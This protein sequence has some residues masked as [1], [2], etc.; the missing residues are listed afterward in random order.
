MIS[1]SITSQKL[2]K[3][4]YCQLKTSDFKPI[5]QDISHSDTKIIEDFLAEAFGEFLAKTDFSD[6]ASIRTEIVSRSASEL[7]SGQFQYGPRF[8]TA[9]QK[10]ISNVFKKINAL[11]ESNRKTFL[12][13]ILLIII[14]DLG[15]IELSKTALDYLQNSEVMIR[16]WAVSCL[17]NSNILKQL[18][19][20]GSD[21]N[22][23]LAQQFAQKLQSV[24]QS[25]QSGDI[26]I[27][28]AQF[29][30]E[31]KQP[32]ANE[33]LNQIAQ[34]RIDL[35]LTWQVENE[36]VDGWILKA[37]ADKTQ[38][39]T[40]NT[41]MTAKNFATLYSLII[42]RYA[43]GE[44]VLSPENTE[45]LVS[46]IV[47]SEK[48]IQQFVPGWQ[49][50]LKRAIEKGGGSILLGEHDSLFGSATAAGQLPPAAGFDYGKNPDGSAKT[51]P[52]MLQKPP[53][54]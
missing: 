37:L 47:Q 52:P 50:S 32:E 9:I 31:L 40:K 35:Y 11:P 2:L 13:T 26:L 27:L 4:L 22:T 20:T 46:V 25:E 28:L 51:A 34:K 53:S 38:E 10:E 8:F 42:Q 18:N 33:I 16:Y 24:A 54:N 30:C 7:E 15:N 5:S 6:I 19:M 45:N 29:A 48:Y 23:L 14:S 39:K 43:I 1:G 3:I 17:T 44:E 21:E 49:G 12:T 41:T 36:M